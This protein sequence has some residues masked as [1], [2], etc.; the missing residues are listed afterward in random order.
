[1]FFLN[2]E[3][4]WGRV[5]KRQH[6]NVPSQAGNGLASDRPAVQRNSFGPENYGKNKFGIGF[7]SLCNQSLFSRSDGDFSETWFVAKPSDFCG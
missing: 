1:M 3:A 2:E 7:R 5:V 4:D 6:C